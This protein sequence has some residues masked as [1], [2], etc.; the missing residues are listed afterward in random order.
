MK[1]GFLLTLLTAAAALQ[2]TSASAMAPVIGNP[3]DVVIGD[4]EGVPDNN[5]NF[6]DAFNIATITTD[7]NTSPTSLLKFSYETTSG[8]TINGV[9]G[10]SGGDD[11][12]NPPAGKSLGLNDAD[13]DTPGDDG[14]PFTLTF[15]N[16]SLSPQGGPYT[17]PGAS[18]IVATQTA[19]VTLWASD[20][21]TA[22][23]RN[24]VVYTD[25]N[26]S[27]SISG[28]SSLI[29]IDNFDLTQ[30]QTGWFGGTNLNN[31][32]APGQQIGTQLNGLAGLCMQ[33]PLLGEN[34]LGWVYIGG[35]GGGLIELVDLAAYRVRADYDT[36]ATLGATPLIDFSYDNTV[37]AGGSVTVGGTFG[38]EHIMLDNE[39]GANGPSSVNNPT[40]RDFYDYWIVSAAAQL[41]QWRGTG[42][43]AGSPDSAFDPSVDPSNDLNPKVRLLDFVAAQIGAQLDTGTVC[44]KTLQIARGTIPGL[45]A[46]RPVVFDLPVLNANFAAQNTSESGG[47][48][49]IVDNNQRAEYQLTASGTQT[50]GAQKTFLPF[51]QASLP[52]NPDFN[53]GDFNAAL[54][55]IQWIA[56]T[57]YLIESDIRSNVGG[58]AGPEGSNPVDVIQ[59]TASEP[60][61]EV[62]HANVVISRGATGNMFLAGGPRLD[63]TT[64]AVEQN[65]SALYFT[66]NYTL[67]TL[68]GP[69]TG[70]DRWQPSVK[71]LNTNPAISGT[72]TDAFTVN[73]LV[74][75]ELGNP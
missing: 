63:S 56:D 17:D 12:I 44:L 70:G 31:A 21:T 27:D 69:L 53:N 9:A 4:A 54:Y 23:S 59:M 72:G 51:V 1:K 66:H 37:F 33:T 46:G 19:T 73:S 20:C 38:G 25:N 52:P 7:D 74:V 2:V 49:T 71:F 10:L 45:T 24:I 43:F 3:G 14:D 64:G 13:T 41:D 5:F 30:D 34:E 40:G 57:L 62:L 26:N 11:P 6:P 55:P 15:R 16:T 65:Y 28:G 68:N 29:I 58:G 42:P 32:G 61:T 60:T 35:P 8:I 22:S 18:G 47:T 75:T 67:S 48:A 36:N 39:G 50:Q